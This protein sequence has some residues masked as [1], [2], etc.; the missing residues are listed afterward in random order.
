MC[1]EENLAM[2]KCINILNLK[3]KPFPKIKQWIWFFA[4]WTLGLISALAIAA[5][6]KLIIKFAS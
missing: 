4:L 1:L 5:P 6:I 3:L 2:R